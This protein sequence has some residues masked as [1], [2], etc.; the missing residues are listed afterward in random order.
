MGFL[1]I[2]LHG[3]CFKW[4][5]KMMGFV[6][7]EQRRMCFYWVSFHD[8]WILLQIGKNDCVF[9]IGFLS[10]YMDFVTCLRWKGKVVFL[11]VFF[12]T[13]HRFSFKWKRVLL[14][15]IGLL[16]IMDFVWKGERNV[17]VFLIG[18]LTWF[19]FPSERA[20]HIACMGW[21]LIQMKNKDCV[22]IGFLFIIHV[23]PFKVKR[24]IL[25]LFSLFLF[26]VHG[27]YFKGGRKIVFLWVVFFS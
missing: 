16:L 12:F 10:C 18:S 1:V 14:F 7:K 20:F 13:I 4:K 2:L 15:I 22:L 24:K 6:S 17:C 26:I 5:G 8:T 3:F 25:F 27:F 11:F 9:F 19:F 21:F 23:F